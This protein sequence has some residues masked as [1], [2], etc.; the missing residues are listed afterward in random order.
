MPAGAVVAA[1]LMSA[2]LAA[3]ATRHTLGALVA[4]AGTRVAR[5]YGPGERIRLHV[6]SLG[7]VVDAEVVRV[8]LANT[9]LMTSGGLVV[10]PN[11]RML[12]TGPAC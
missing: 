7:E 12:R 4:G 10:V 6:P 1:G 2:V 3:V 5:P 9:T 11:N 8:G